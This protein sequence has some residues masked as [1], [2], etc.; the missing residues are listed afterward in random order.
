LEIG[1]FAGNVIIRP[2]NPKARPIKDAAPQPTEYVISS[3]TGERIPVEKLQEHLK[4]N[5][6]DPEFLEQRDRR[7]MEKTHQ[8]LVYAPGSSI[9]DSLKQL[10]ERRSDIFG[11]GAEETSIG[12][13][14][15]DLSKEQEKKVVWDGFS[16]SSD[17][18]LRAAAMNVTPEE[19]RKH[20]FEMA[21][22][23][24]LIPDP[25]K[26]RIG[27][28][29]GGIAPPPVR[30][31][32]FTPP[33]V[34]LPMMRPPAPPGMGFLP[35]PL[36]HFMPLPP[37]PM[38]PVSIAPPPIPEPED[39]D[40][41]EPSFKRQKQDNSAEEEFLRTYTGPITFK[42]QVPHV[43]DKP[44]WKL[45]GQ[46][47][48]LT[49]APRDSMTTLKNRIQDQLGIPSAKQKVQFDGVYVKDNQTMAACNIKPGS[50]VFLQVKE[51]GGRKK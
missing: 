35:P 22:F 15:G 20:D 17:S 9:G 48:N 46:V 43:A 47:V 24:G 37:R 31:P 12:R 16:G 32:I 40:E 44:E 4:Y 23:Q 49:L 2:Y 8:E 21:K 18:A 29:G 27:P 38:V 14:I 51:R 34:T 5:L 7:L 10:A 28:Q 33:S 42:V 41:D 39:E 11:S 50:V 6:L 45:N 36:Q 19:Q 25:E 30:L 3:I 26:D 13:K 1:I